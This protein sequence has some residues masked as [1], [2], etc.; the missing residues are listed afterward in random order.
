MFHE[1][2]DRVHGPP[3]FTTPK[4]TVQHHDKV[5]ILWEK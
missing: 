5:V 3:N 2:L 4:D 1:N